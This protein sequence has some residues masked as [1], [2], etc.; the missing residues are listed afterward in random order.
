MTIGIPRALLYYKYGGLWETFFRRL[1]CE[2]QYSHETT[3][4]TLQDGIRFSID[5]ACIPSKI[6]MGHVYELIGKCDYILV[7]RIERFGVREEVCVKFNAMY[8]IV[9]NTFPDAPLIC[10]DINAKEGRDERRGFIDMGKILHKSRT[11]AVNAYE[12]AKAAQIRMEKELAEAQNRILGN[13]EAFKILIVTHPY[14]I[15][16]PLLGYPVIKAVEESGGSPVFAD[17]LDN[18]ACIE[19]STELSE[20]LYWTYS[21]ELV[22][23]ISLCKGQIDGI[24]L[25]TAFPCGPDSLVNELLMRKVKDIPV[26]HIILDEP[27][28]EAGLVTRIES[29]LDIIRERKRN[30]A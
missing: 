2:V 1:G 10:Y 18:S 15:H 24:L 17:R 13:N 29:F 20:H 21:K 9:R 14:N 23:A 5:E 6:F 8:D 27:G 22:G 7:P 25:I 16:D 19:K 3:M 30:H 12:A 28:G 11:E 4:Q 26:A